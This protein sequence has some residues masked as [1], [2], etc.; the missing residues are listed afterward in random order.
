MPDIVPSLAAVVG[1]DH[2]LTDGLDAYAV[3]W[4]RKFRGRP[5]AVVRP[6]SVAEVAGCIRTCRDHRVSVVPQGGNTGL[7]AGATPDMSGRQIVLSL[8]RMNRVRSIDRTSMTIEVEAGCPLAVAQQ[9]A[10]EVGRIIP[11]RLAS[12]GTAQIGGLVATNAGGINVLRY[13]STRHFTLGVEA[14]LADGTIVDALR[15]LRKDNAGYD[16]KQLLVGSEGTLGIVTAA[17]LR[18]MPMPRYTVTALL[19]VPGPA[20]AVKILEALQTELGEAISAFEFMSSGSVDLVRRHRGHDVP[21]AL[22]RWYLLVELTSNIS[23]LAADTQEA[24]AAVLDSGLAIDCVLASS[25][26]QASELWNIRESITESE[27]LAGGSIKHDVSVPTASLPAFLDQ[28]VAAVEKSF[29]SAICSLFGHLGDGN[30]HFNVVAPE[31]AE[32]INRIVHDLIVYH[33]GS[34]SAEHGIG[35][36]RVDELVRCKPAAELDLMS[37]IKRSFDPYDILNPG[38]VI[39][40]S[41]PETGRPG[42]L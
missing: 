35:A 9:H 19:S 30:I 42:R 1:T 40:A 31:P 14:V 23:G 4:R 6:A 27:Q 8:S 7:A 22:A 11:L 25:R 2:V 21:I 17:V 18:L 32:P 33:G 41:D 38:K 28:A 29:P 26:Q 15:H 3:D 37:R 5:L 10:D 39:A 24:L 13:G 20:D 12:E 36:Y 16:W 34:I